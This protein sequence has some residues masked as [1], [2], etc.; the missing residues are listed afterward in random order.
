MRKMKLPGYSDVQSLYVGTTTHVVRARPVGAHATVVLKLLRERYPPPRSLA[1]LQREHTILS[2]IDVA[3]VVR[4]QGFSSV[5]GRPT[6]TLHDDQAVALPDWRVERKPSPDACIRLMVELARI[7]GRVHASGVIHRDVTPA[8]IIVTPDDHPVLI[9]FGLATRLATERS[10]PRIRHLH[11]TL[12]FLSPEQTGRTNRGVD[13]RTDLYSLGATLF[14]LLA[15]RPPFEETDAIAMIHAHLARR[16]PSLSTMRDDLPP[17]VPAI[18][19]RLLEKAPERRYQSAFGLADDLERALAEETDFELGRTDFAARFEVSTTL[20]GRDR[21]RATINEAVERLPEGGNEVLLVRGY[22]GIGK[23]SLVAEVHTPLLA[24][25]GYYAIGKFDQLE[26]DRPYSGIVDALRSLLTQILAESEGSLEMLRA[27]VTKRLPGLTG[28]L[29]EDL[30]E[31]E[32]LIGP[33]PPAP[34]LPPSQTQNRLLGAFAR[35]LEALCRAE[36][37]VAL[38]FDDLQWADQAALRLFETVVSDAQI[39][40]LLVIGAYRDNEVHGAHPLHHTLEALKLAQVSLGVVELGPLNERDV[41]AIIRAT[42][43][44]AA[45]RAPEL[46]SIVYRKTGG[47][48]FYT[49]QILRSL[50]AQGALRFDVESRTWTWARI[51]VESV[52]PSENVVELMTARIEALPDATRE[53]MA[54]AACV[55]GN[56]EL[57]TVAT[58]MKL[59]IAT[60]A[61]H[62]WPAIEAGLLLPLSDANDGVPSTTHAEMTP[63]LEFLHDRVQQAAYGRVSEDARP[64]LHLKIGRQLRN[65]ASDLAVLSVV[66]HLNKGRALI[67]SPEERLDLADLNLQAARKAR[68]SAAWEETFGFAD[69]AVELIDSRAGPLR[70]DADTLLAEAAFLSG[71]PQRAEAVFEALVPRLSDPVEKAALQATRISLYENAG[72]Y[73]RCLSIGR[74][75]LRELGVDIPTDPSALTREVERLRHQFRDHRARTDVSTLI[76]HP[77]K[78]E[79]KWRVVQELLMHMSA[80]AYFLSEA[81]CE[82]VVLRGA[83]VSLEHGHC[84]ASAIAYGWLGVVLTTGWDE[85]ALAYQFG[86]L[87]FALNERYP[88]PELKSKL[89]VLFGLFVKHWRQ[90][91]AHCIPEMKS[92]VSFGLESGDLA[93]AGYAAAILSRKLLSAGRPLSEVH[94]QL[95]ST[96]PLFIKARSAPVLEHQRIISAAVDVLRTPG[97]DPLVLSHGDYDEAESLR[98]VTEAQFGVGIAVY[99]FY[100]LLV[101][102]IFERFEAAQGLYGAL[103]DKLVWLG[104]M[105]HVPEAEMLGALSISRRP[106]PDL[107][108]AQETQRELEAA[109]QRLLIW[110]DSSPD[111]YGDKAALVQAELHRLRGE[112]AP[113][114]RS[115]ERSIQ[116]AGRQG[117]AWNEALACEA[118]ARF[119]DDLGALRPARAYRERAYILYR[120]WGADAKARLLNQVSTEDLDARLHVTK[121]SLSHDSSSLESAHAFVDLEAFAKA[122][123]AISETLELEPL[124]RTL[125]RIVVEDAGAT[126]ALLV[127]HRDDGRLFLEAQVLPSQ[128]PKVLVG[129][130]LDDQARDLPV[131]LLEQVSRTKQPR[132]VSDAQAQRG[133]EHLGSREARSILCLPLVTQGRSVGVLHLENELAPS[134]FTADRIE[135]LTLL[136]GQL[137]IAIEKARLYAGLEEIVKS[138]TSELQNALRELER[139]QT[140]L[141]MQE[142][143]AS[144]GALVAGVAH[145]VNTPLGAVCSNIETMK[146]ALRRFEVI[147]RQELE[148]NPI[149]EQAKPGDRLLEKIN[150]MLSVSLTATDRIRGIVASLRQFARL[151]RADVDLMRLEDGIEN[152]LVVMQHALRHGIEVHRDF[153]ELPEV[154]C[155]PSRMNQVFMNILMNAVQA[156]DGAGRIDIRTRHE[157]PDAVVEITDD[158]RGIPADDLPKI[159][160]PGFTTK[161]PKIGTGLGLSIVHGIVVDDHH[162]RIA[163]E[164]TEGIGTTFIVRIPLAGAKDTRQ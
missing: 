112:V 10:A 97:R 104:G 118:A 146:T 130:P 157:G 76:D 65:R 132:V 74:T 34:Q 28:L 153:G 148:H 147:R 164:S 89:H 142:K 8:N 163:V 158:G 61:D 99:D 44:P 128:S 131:K 29:A 62:L 68:A 135:V 77:E 27:R 92:A 121:R 1:A 47:N 126:S 159:F 75:A 120:R 53:A 91:I 60:L 81:L 138:R 69:T 115:Y 137:A 19:A 64:A 162:G 39:A 79:P 100:R 71:R 33:Q 144:L 9:D 15:G 54:T 116:I 151:D 140:R 160:D 109:L 154:P 155:Y 95:S 48:P 117:L 70:N 98:V 150:A 24:R 38:F 55:G 30:P 25:S 2:A 50:H 59:D 149:V 45:Q 156:I 46:A 101:A 124:L 73:E 37:P 87:S 23:S 35:L 11:G 18:V 72:Q 122:S 58:A 82:A 26:R 36:R 136:S 52:T 13:Y 7:V 145:E 110:A 141:I 94:A 129:R 111:N 21:E 51:D 5:D 12:S 4:V 93:F 49:Q 41:E 31:L 114:I 143:M 107:K 56:F 123:R 57:T 119:Q 90:P 67:S 78:T 22:S 17:A 152:T 108:A 3:G 20:Y 42:L 125:M 86:E 134:V 113:A 66:Q 96:I 16:P 103:R 14:A 40:H 6:L 106:A 139:A 133:S 161:G 105:C 127:L 63:V 84:P 102:V 88:S 80:P 83:T 85:Y 32:A 43:V